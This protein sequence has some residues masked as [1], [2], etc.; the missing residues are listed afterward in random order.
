MVRLIVLFL[1]I[2]FI[3]S[4][5]LFCKVKNSAPKEDLIKHGKIGLGIFAAYL[6]GEVGFILVVE[7]DYYVYW[8]LFAAPCIAFNGIWHK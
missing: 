4:I 5:M 7:S 8:L 2:N 1:L 3:F 6:L